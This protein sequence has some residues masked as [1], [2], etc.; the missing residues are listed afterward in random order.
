MMI[1]QVSAALTRRCCHRANVIRCFSAIDKV[2]ENK[3]AEWLHQRGDKMLEH[4]KKLPSDIHKAPAYS[5]G[6]RDDYVHT[7]I[8][9]DN[10]IRPESVQ[11]RIDLDQAWK[12]TSDKIRASFEKSGQSVAEFIRASTTKKEFQQDM[13]KLHHMAKRVNDAIIDDSLRFNGRSPVPHARRFHFEERIKE[14]I[15]NNQ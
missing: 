14:A 9:A 7:K 4:G 13:D 11:R 8:L 10:N 2:A 6:L 5:L 12:E 1:H 15:E 3:I